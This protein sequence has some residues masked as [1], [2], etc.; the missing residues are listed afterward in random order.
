LRVANALWAQES[1]KFLDSYT[2]PLREYYESEARNLDFIGKLEPSRQAINAWVEDRT[3]DKIKDLFPTGSLDSST[4]LVL[5]NAVYFKGTWVDPFLR[6]ETYDQ[7]FRSPGGELSVPMMHRSGASSRYAYAETDSLQAL[8]LPY[9]GGDLSMLVLLP[10]GDELSG[11]EGAL[12]QGL[13]DE[14][15]GKLSV[16]RINVILPR[17]KFSSGYTLNTE[18]SS[19]GMPTAFQYG[20]ADFSGMDGSR[21]LY[22]GVVIHKAFVDVNEEGTEAAAATGVGM[23][24]GSAMPP[25]KPLEFRADHPF[26]FLIRDNGSGAILF[27]GRMEDPGAGE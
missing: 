23:L 4:R 15:Y 19:L 17:F 7:P 12:S 16:T 20:P 18:L 8:E 25:E 10:K 2:G 27:M 22:I 26:I 11:L 6:D 1:Y 5:T 14:L 21:D 24:A 9:K 13:L 3:E